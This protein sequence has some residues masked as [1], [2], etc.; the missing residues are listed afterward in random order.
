MDSRYLVQV[1]WVRWT[2]PYRGEFNG[3]S[4]SQLRE[5]YESVLNEA[6]ELR[7]ERN[8]E[9]IENRKLESIRLYQ[10]KEIIRNTISIREGSKKNLILQKKLQENRNCFKKILDEKDKEIRN[11]RQTKHSEVKSTLSMVR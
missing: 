10:E 1:H 2:S 7:A 11:L 6:A 5:K 9:K 3:P 8:N 4:L